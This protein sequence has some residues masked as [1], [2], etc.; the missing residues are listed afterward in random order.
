MG[1]FSENYETYLSY[2]SSILTYD[3]WGYAGDGAFRLAVKD[4]V[5]AASRSIEP[6]LAGRSATGATALCAPR[7]AAVPVHMAN[8]RDA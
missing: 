6:Q 4:A 7:W 8:Q 2:S 1:Y 5:D 3:A